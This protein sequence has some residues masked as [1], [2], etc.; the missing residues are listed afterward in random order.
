MPSVGWLAHRAFFKYIA[1]STLA[2]RKLEVIS[3]AVVALLLQL[4]I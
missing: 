4:F 1:T 3:A 2:R